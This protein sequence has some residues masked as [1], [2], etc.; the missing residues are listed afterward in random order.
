MPVLNKETSCWPPDLFQGLPGAVHPDWRWSV[1]RTRSRAEKSVVRQL[2]AN[3]L[4][5]Y[6]PQKERRT[7][8]Q[9]RS[10]VS[11]LPLFPGYVFLKGDEE[12]LEVALRAKGV[13]QYIAV[14]DQQRLEHS[15]LQ[16]QRVIESGIPFWPEERL[17][18]GERVEIVS[19]PLQG[20]TGSVARCGSS[21]RLIVEVDLL[22]QGVS[23]EIDTT[24]V[25]RVC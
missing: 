22:Q 23:V 20:V 10:V 16:L 4:G 19:G 15:L 18:P 9:R 6:L 25:R 1:L 3:D 8:H 5:C 11:S 12:G 7:R 2:I 21:E 24:N 17:Q 13:A 14:E